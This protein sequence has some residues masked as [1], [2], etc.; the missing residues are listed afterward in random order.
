MAGHFIYWN[1]TSAQ[2]EDLKTHLQCTQAPNFF[3]EYA[4]QMSDRHPGWTTESEQLITDIRNTPELTIASRDGLPP[5]KYIQMVAGSLNYDT[6][7]DNLDWFSELAR[8]KVGLRDLT[9][10]AAA[11]WPANKKMSVCQ[12]NS[13]GRVIIEVYYFDGNRINKSHGAAK[14]FDWRDYQY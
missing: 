5:H 11:V 1:I 3:S 12:Q 8:P 2:L 7:G 6:L 13:T 14:K 9:Q 10:L 4:H